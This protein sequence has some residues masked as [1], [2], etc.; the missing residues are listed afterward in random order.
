[1]MMT[2]TTKMTTRNSLVGV[3]DRAA[4]ARIHSKEASM[5]HFCRPANTKSDETPPLMGQR[6]PP[7]SQR[8]GERRTVPQLA[9][10]RPANKK[11]L[12]STSRHLAETLVFLIARR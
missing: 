1:M 5:G 9:G 3:G 7:K 12:V 6:Q 4:E 8:F 2:T 10:G 11:R